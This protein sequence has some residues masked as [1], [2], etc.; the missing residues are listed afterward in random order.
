MT[1][2]LE[3]EGGT[4]ARW[5]AFTLEKR[6]RGLPPVRSM[7]APRADIPHL[8][9]DRS[10]VAYLWPSSFHSNNRDVQAQLCAQRTG[11]AILPR[12]LGG[13]TPPPGRDTYVGR[14][15]SLSALRKE[16]SSRGI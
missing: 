7:S 1:N 5:T 10:D 15:K 12:P 3:G 16:M 8:P 11:H 9:Y 14:P 4:A 13:A 6:G 2:P